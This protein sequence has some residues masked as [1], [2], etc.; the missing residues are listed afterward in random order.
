MRYAFFLLFA[1]AA[2]EGTSATDAASDTPMVD[3]PAADAPSDTTA[4]DSAPVDAGPADAMPADTAADVAPVDVVPVDAGP[5]TCGTM[6]CGASQYCLVQCSGID[7]GSGWDPHRCVDVPA[8][9]A[10]TPDCA[11]LHPCGSITGGSRCTDTG[12]RVLTCQLCA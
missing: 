12:A 5:V 3:H 2:C 7:A 11:C 6:T 10:A 4:V 8:E 1:L 9:C